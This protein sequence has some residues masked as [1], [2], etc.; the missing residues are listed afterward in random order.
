MKHT[1][2]CKFAPTGKSRLPDLLYAFG[3]ADFVAPVDEDAFAAKC[4]RADLPKKSRRADLAKES[5]NCHA[6]SGKISPSG[7]TVRGS[8]SPNAGPA[9]QEYADCSGAGIY[10]GCSPGRKEKTGS[11]RVENAGKADSGSPAHPRTLH[12]PAAAR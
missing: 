6:N 2:D 5:R 10:S 12:P 9:C 11:L 8:C 1:A 7:L 3:C 4:R